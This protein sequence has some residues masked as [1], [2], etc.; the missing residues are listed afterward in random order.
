MSVRVI[1]VCRPVVA[2]VGT[3]GA[4]PEIWSY[5]HRNSQG[6][7]WHPDTGAL[8][9]IEHGQAGGDE[10]NIIKRGMNYGWPLVAYGTEYD[11]RPINGG[12][13]SAPGMEQPA[14]YWDPAIGPTGMAF[15]NG[16]LI[17]EW[18][19]NLFVASH[20]GQHIARLVLDGERVTG[21]ERL[22]MD[23]RQMMRWVGQG[24][25]GALWVLTDNAGGRVIRLAPAGR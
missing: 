20:N 14:Y 21:E 7:A 3:T 10:I 5:G 9:S 22:L 2:L 25:D 23:Q 11:L 6:L 16:D 1:I 13:T 8:W 15:Y 18:K 17:P 4:L 19:G 24:P 12:R